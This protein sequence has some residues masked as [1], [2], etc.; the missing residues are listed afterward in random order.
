MLFQALQL[1]ADRFLDIGLSFL[2]GSPLG[3][4]TRQGRTVR[5]KVAA[6]IL[7]DDHPEF[8]QNLHGFMHRRD[9]GAAKNETNP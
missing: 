2:P 6:F 9:A 3:D 1:S 4:A 8:Y 5:H 7:L